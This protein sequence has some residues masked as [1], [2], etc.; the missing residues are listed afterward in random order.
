ML[1]TKKIFRTATV[2]AAAFL[3]LAGALM[4]LPARA[5]SIGASLSCFVNAMGGVEFGKKLLTGAEVKDVSGGKKELTLRFADDKSLVIYTVN[6]H[7]FVN[8][9]KAPV[10]YY[11][12]AGQL[13]TVKTG[14]VTITKSDK[15][16]QNA[17]GQAVHYLESMTFTLDTLP[18]ELYLYLYI[19]SQVMGVQFGNG[20]GTAA[21][22]HPDEATP[23]KAVLTL[24][25]VTASSAG[26]GTAS[27]QG[28]PK[29]STGGSASGASKTEEKTAKVI[30]DNTI[31][32]EYTV[33]IPT[34]IVVD[35]KT[36]TAGY[37]VAAERFDLK[38][39]AYVTVGAD[40]GGELKNG[41]AAI[42]FTNT[43]EAG[44]LTK[45]GDKL[46]GT[47]ALTGTNPKEGR[48]EGAVRFTINYFSGE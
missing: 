19:D 35:K 36:R 32:G 39:G 21:S 23:Y 9:D 20:S 22:N 16:A 1:K 31:S 27:S 41:D 24:Q 6:A 44:K 25:P 3:L 10:G 45:T 2:L 34:E 14:D 30:F 38:E 37:V 5:A 7:V 47:I 43:L 8:P 42:S 11:D 46:T 29:G 48:Y 13:H 28:Q 26:S 12:A 18:N 33:S 40:A 17:E 15:T 4:P